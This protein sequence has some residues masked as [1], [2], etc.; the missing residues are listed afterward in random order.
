MRF[1]GINAFTDTLLIFFRFFFIITSEAS[2]AAF[3]RAE[4]IVYSFNCSC[5]GICCMGDR[6][7]P[8]TWITVITGIEE[9][10]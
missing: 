8:E 1:T 3:Y 10:R 6:Y 9:E 2:Y 5:S 7:K 4:G